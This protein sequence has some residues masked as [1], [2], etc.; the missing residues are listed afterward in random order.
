MIAF[1]WMFPS[2]A[3]AQGGS[4]SAV[5]LD[6]DNYLFTTPL[7]GVSGRLTHQ[8]VNTPL[9]I[10]VGA[11]RLTRQS[12][13]IGSTCTGL[14]PAGTCPPEPLRDNGRFIAGTAGVGIRIFD[15]RRIA[16]NL[17][18][19]VGFSVIN[20]DTHGMTSGGSISARKEL[21]DSELG[22]EAVWSPWPRL[23]F[24]IEA[25]FA[26]GVEEPQQNEGQIDGYSPFEQSF[27]V[28]HGRIGL[29]WR[30]PSR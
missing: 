22:V 16:L 28:M 14:V 21:W 30:L 3:A 24:G 11:E 25:G 6:V 9:F 29:T 27:R 7:I 4:I 12:R 13:R 2:A 23:P 18:G 20:L 17:T 15:R 8:V 10:L 26:I 5:V 19:D 1:A